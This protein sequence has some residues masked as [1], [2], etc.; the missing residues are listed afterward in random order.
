MDKLGAQKQEMTEIAPL[1]LG[2]SLS[3]E[4]PTLIASSLCARQLSEMR[5]E[6]KQELRRMQLEGQGGEG[7][8]MC[9]QMD[10]KNERVAL[11]AAILTSCVS[12][13]SVGMAAHVLLHLLLHLVQSL[14]LEPHP[15][16]ERPGHVCPR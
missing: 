7:D 11:G 1:L 2:Q 4:A 14:H 8:K 12:V 6:Q 15:A 9:A 5:A 10:A 16:T 13:L 3:S